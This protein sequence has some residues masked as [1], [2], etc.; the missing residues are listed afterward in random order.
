V[1]EPFFDTNVLV[2]LL[3][4]DAARA[5]AAEAELAEGGHLSVQV[6]NEF[7]S[8]ARKKARLAWSDIDEVLEPLRS[9]CTVHPLTLDTH[10]RAR[11]LAERH[12]LGFWDAL[13]VASALEARCTVLLTEDLQHGQRFEGL[14]VRNPFRSV[15]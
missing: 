7:T 12:R 4:N 5:D 8:V 14:A 1:A 6:L 10:D 11:K 3:S 15:G 13:I 2:Y 9:I